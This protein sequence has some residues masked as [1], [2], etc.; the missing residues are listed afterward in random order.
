MRKGVVMKKKLTISQ[1]RLLL[2]LVIVVIFVSAYQF[3]YVKYE[4]LSEDYATR[5]QELKQQMAQREGDLAQEDT[6]T[7]ETQEIN[8]SINTIIDEFPVRLTKVDNLIFIADMEQELGMEI[9]SVNF[10]D[11]IS[12]YTTILP[13]RSTDGMDA[14]TGITATDAAALPDNGTDVA[15]STAEGAEG[16][17]PYMTALVS[18]ISIDFLTTEEEFLKLVDYINTYPERTSL[19][20]VSLSY[21][22][23]TGELRGSMI[24]NRYIL[25]GSGKTYELPDT[26]D[27]SIGTD[28]L[29]GTKE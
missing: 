15:D 22:N 10:Q 12:F 6:L 23:S 24:I 26:G 7:Q 13:I 18:P 17:G 9:P 27:I 29:F 2:C 14:V 8:R 1:K 11:N 21:D 16:T 5:T 28:N 25:A 4:G 19:S 20:D 3:I